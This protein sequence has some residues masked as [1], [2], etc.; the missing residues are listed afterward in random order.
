MKRYIL[1][2]I[3]II[4]LMMS[5]ACG[6]QSQTSGLTAG[7]PG[8]TDAA[9]VGT[10][11]QAESTA[12]SQ[13]GND[14]DSQAGNDADSQSGNALDS[15][16]SKIPQGTASPATEEPSKE[17]EPTMDPDTWDYRM[18]DGDSNMHYTESQ[19]T[20]E[21]MPYEIRVNKQANC[22]TVYKANKKGEYVKPVKAMVCSAGRKTPLGTFTTGSK[23]YWKAMIHHVWA[24]YATRITGDILFHSVPYDTH[25]KNSLITG[26][27][28]RLGSIAS[29]GCIRLCVRDAKWLVEN[30]PSGTKVTIYNSSDPGPL[31]KPSPIRISSQCRWDPTDPDSRN[32][33]NKKKSTIT[34]VKDRKVE[35]GTRVNYLENVTAFDKNTYNMTTSGIHVSTKL[36]IK[37]PGSYKVKYT[38][39][40]SK[41]KT[42]V[43]KAVF[44]VVDTSAPVISGIPE[45]YYV[46]DISKVSADSIKKMLAVTDNGY[47]LDKNKY[48]EVNYD[49]GRAVITANDKYGNSKNINVTVIEDNKPPVLKLANKIKEPLPITTEITESYARKRIKTISDNIAKLNVDSPR[50]TIKPSGWGVKITYEV[51]DYAGNRTSA[52]ETLE[53]EKVSV[54]TE[55]NGTPTVKD[56]KNDKQLKKFISVTSEKTGKPVKYSLK[57]SRKKIGSNKKDKIYK[58]TYDVSYSSSAGTKKVSKSIKVKEAKHG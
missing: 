25:E 23:Y 12:D 15:T 37:K 30:C 13:S 58:V 42:I 57:I 22:I 10:E 8:A 36:N 26:Y 55:A 19:E 39:K 48:L 9:D 27:Y 34:G 11:Q 3:T 40:D 49:Q 46:R 31:G 35:R 20:P 32:P 14:T 52:A 53:Y 16:E 44:T 21:V 5:T 38:F 45:K 28:N 29:A 1:I 24:Q 4:T 7:A 17:P 2:S 18:V 54:K 33:L 41:G 43:K 47:P 56:I 50:I 51:T 6:G